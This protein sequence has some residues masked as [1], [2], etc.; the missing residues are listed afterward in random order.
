M[1]EDW[2]DPDEEAPGRFVRRFESFPPLSQCDALTV[3]RKVRHGIHSPRSPN[4][5]H[6]H[7]HALA[8][9]RTRKPGVPTAEDLVVLHELR[10]SCSFLRQLGQDMFDKCVASMTLWERSDQSCTSP[11]AQRGPGAEGAASGE[12]GARLFVG[13]TRFE[14]GGVVRPG[15]GE[16][17]V[18][19]SALRHAG[20]ATTAGTR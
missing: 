14:A 18:F 7:R 15:I 4:L 10:A 11:S 20:E 2:A 17:V 6:R 1:P 5:V 12:P 19:D 9:P 13:G 3:L 16:A 8:A